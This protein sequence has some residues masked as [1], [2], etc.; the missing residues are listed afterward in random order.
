[1]QIK[2]TDNIDFALIPKKSNGYEIIAEYY[3]HEKFIDLLKVPIPG[4]H[5][6]SNT[7]AAIANPCSGDSHLLTTTSVLQE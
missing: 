4:T 2:K 1:M 3:E 5:N 6:L 7:I